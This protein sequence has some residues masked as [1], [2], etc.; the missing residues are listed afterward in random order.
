MKRHTSSSSALP[1]QQSHNN[2]FL[3]TYSVGTVCLVMKY[4]S[5]RFDNGSFCS[6][7]QLYTLCCCWLYG[8]E[9]LKN[10]IRAWRSSNCLSCCCCPYRHEISN[11]LLN[12]PRVQLF[13][14]LK[15]DLCQDING[16]ALKEH[17]LDGSAPLRLCKLTQKRRFVFVTLLIWVSVLRP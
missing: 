12:I 7:I 11:I 6:Y 5:I 17:F 3:H 4:M 10:S 9:T 15:A 2:H 8:M 14:S 1:L 13:T 16:G